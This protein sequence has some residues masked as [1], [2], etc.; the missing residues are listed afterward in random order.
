MN[1]QRLY[2]LDALRGIAVILVVFFHYFYRYDAIYGHNDIAVNWSIIGKY[3][4]ELFFM[5]SG[6]VIFWTLNRSEKPLDFIISRFSR[7]FPAYWL[8]IILTF[9]A[10][11]YFG[12][13]GR[14][15][16]SS[17]ALFNSLMFHEYLGI[18]HVDGVYWTLTVELTFYFW[19]FSLFIAKQL[20]NAVKIFSFIIILSIISSLDIVTVPYLVQKILL[21]EYLP[22][23][24]AG[25]C[26]FQITNSND[27]K[28]NN[29]AFVL[30]SLLS[31]LAIYEIKEFFI[32]ACIYLIFYLA[33]TGKIAFLAFKPFV[34]MGGISYSLYLVHQN[35]GYII[36]N[37]LYEISINPILATLVAFTASILIAS[38]MFKFIE[39]PC[40]RLIRN[41]Y[42]NSKKMQYFS[43]KLSITSSTK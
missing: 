28:I 35:I 7:L 34:F 18:P 13:S 24:T 32:I 43:N 29:Y 30:F 27:K 1:N 14:E 2:E 15:T 23:F 31:T 33:V 12:L 41:S 37:K 38:F 25:I 40:L 16:S 20:H 10:V 26:F 9:S 11:Y 22:F 39:K 17:E 21:L 19:M 3:G 5:V 4:V 8:A 6:F 42:K 36:I